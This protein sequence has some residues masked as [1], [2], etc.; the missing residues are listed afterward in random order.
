MRRVALAVAFLAALA[1]G[2]GSDENRRWTVDLAPINDSGVEGQAEL[3]LDGEELLVRIDAR[4]L[5]PDRVH[6]QRLHGFDGER[7][8]SFCPG[9]DDVDDAGR[10]LQ[11]DEADAA[12]GEVI[13]RLVPYP[14][15]DD[16]G[17]IDF[18]LTYRV[19]ADQLVLT[20]RA[21]V[22]FGLE[23]PSSRTGEP[24]FFPDVPVA[25]GQLDLREG[26]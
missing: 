21:L 25:C 6:G 2:C 7:Q 16:A 22:L 20:P 26:D 8:P 3:V 18:E 17:T 24:E 9:L 5:T 1:S 13:M 14:T 4:G 19:D 23:A 10:I 15:T 11:N 12:Y